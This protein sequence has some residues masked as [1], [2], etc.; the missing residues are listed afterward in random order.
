MITSRSEEEIQKNRCRHTNAD[1]DRQMHTDKCRF[2][3]QIQT[4][5]DSYRCRFRHMQIQTDADAIQA[6]AIQL[7]TVATFDIDKQALE[8]R[9][10]ADVGYN[11]TTSGGSSSRGAYGPFGWVVLTT[12]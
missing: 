2:R 11:C 6:D 7:D 5:A 1:S 8:A 12:K 3:Q 9:L 4:A 10:E